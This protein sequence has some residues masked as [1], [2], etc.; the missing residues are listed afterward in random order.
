MGL[1]LLSIVSFTAIL[2]GIWDASAR[3][4]QTSYELAVHT[5]RVAEAEQLSRIAGHLL[6]DPSICQQNLGGQTVTPGNQT[7]LTSIRHSLPSGALGGAFLQVNQPTHSMNLLAM[8]LTNA[9]NTGGA[10]YD[11]ELFMTFDSDTRAIVKTVPLRVQLGGGNTI[12]TCVSL[13]SAQAAV[14]A[15]QCPPG[16][17]VTGTLA[18][19]S[20]ICSV[21]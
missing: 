4:L 14:S 13:Q 21:P 6:S 15:Q 11:V 9:V 18:N 16:E 10:N 8:G 20:L 19:G 7:P 5:E 1:P 17:F 3:S 2:Y 12:S